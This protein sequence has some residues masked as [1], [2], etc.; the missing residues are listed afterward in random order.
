MKGKKISTILTIAGGIGVVA[1][2]FSSIITTLKIKN[3]EEQ[4]EIKDFL[5]EHWKEYI[6]SAAICLSTV[7]CIFGAN[8]LNKKQQAALITTYGL[9]NAS[10]KKY[11][12]KVKEVCGEETHKNILDEVMK[13]ECNIARKNWAYTFA[14]AGTLALDDDDEPD[15]VRTFYDPF[16]KRYFDCPL[17]K[18]IDA[19]Y[20]INRNYMINGAVSMN[21]FYEF[22]G[23]PIIE[24]GDDYG[25][26]IDELQDFFWIDFFHNSISLDDG[27]KII[28]I[29]YLFDP[30]PI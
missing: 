11:K 4:L 18:V 23:I 6:P 7:A 3:D 28:A 30:M 24:N 8:I 2:G 17:S 22:I 19:E 12:D 25:W 21:D 9:L 1:T 27:M 26:S 16:S 10:Y 20:H 5:K 14:G 15:I 29:E 13:E